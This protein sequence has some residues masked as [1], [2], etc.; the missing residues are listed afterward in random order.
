MFFAAGLIGYVG[1]YFKGKGDASGHAD[2]LSNGC[3]LMRN[4][5]TGNG[6]PASWGVIV[7]LKTGDAQS[8]QFAFDAS[9]S[10]TQRKILFRTQWDGTWSPWTNL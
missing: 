3:Y 9:V 10:S 8:I 2:N 7:S 1:D 6:Y 4:A 5:N